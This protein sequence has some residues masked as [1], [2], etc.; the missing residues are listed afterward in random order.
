M[1][2]LTERELEVLTLVAKGKSNQE[3]AD[4]LFVRDVTVKTH[5]NTIFKKL[6]VKNRTQAVL[7]AIQL[8]MVS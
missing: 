2:T 4:T 8:N 6:N 3:I 5:L 7:L 1:E